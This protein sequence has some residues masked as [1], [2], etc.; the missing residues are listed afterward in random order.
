MT[1]STQ[2]LPGRDDIIR[3]ELPNGITVLVR[4]NTHAQSVVIAGSLD[5]GSLFDPPDAIGVASFAASMPLR[6]TA[7]R[8]F[9][10]IHEML[11]SNGASLSISGGRHSAG[12]SGKSLAEDLPMLLN[13]L[14]DALRHPA[15]PV[16]QVERL[17]GQ[18]VTAIKI[19][20]QDTRY[21]A[22]RLFRELAYPAGHPY[23]CQ[24]D[25]TL[26]TVTAITRDQLSEF[27]WTHYGP[28]GMMMVM[29]GAVDAEHAIRLVEDCLGDWDNPAQPDLPVL[30]SVPPILDS[31]TQTVVMPG[32][33]QTD[34]V[35]GAPG[36][37]RLSGD[38]LAASLANNIL[39]VFGMYG[40]I[41]AEVR[42]KHGMAYYS[43]SRLEGGLGPG[44]WRVIAGVAPANIAQA[45]ET[46]R[47][48]I[49]RMT[50]EL[51]TEDELADNRANFIGRL[52][53]QL[54]SN[55]GVAGTLLAMERYG[56]GLDY[57]RGYADQ[58]NAVTAND[59]RAAARHYLDADA[60]ALAVAG[61]DP[62]L[63]T[64]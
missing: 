10:A 48:E 46:I 11:E 35:L 20:D 37:S 42:E 8:D 4:E 64:A 15:F 38:W 2:S 36:P 60:C 9:A 62:V 51:V 7:E 23:A 47:H 40:R 5:A 18:L 3:R 49:R 31:R 43:Y 63:A 28:R 17:R 34:I 45:V 25:G 12:F 14:S 22:G 54:E 33:S 27:H 16:E 30:P 1:A 13:L 50:T 57:L 59:V 21:V 61:P 29:V 24:S 58:V 44:P 39:G 41:G 19:R 53:L 32:K 26:E 6:G 52:P 56:L 55:E